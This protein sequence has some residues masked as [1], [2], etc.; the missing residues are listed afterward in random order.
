VFSSKTISAKDMQN[1]E[2]YFTDENCGVGIRT[3]KGNVNI[4]GNLI[5]DNETIVNIFES[6]QS[7]L[8]YLFIHTVSSTEGKVYLYNN[9]QL[10]LK[11]SGLSITS[12]SE[13]LD[14][15]QGYRNLF[16]FANG[17]DD[18]HYIELGATPDCGVIEAVDSDSRP[19]KGLGLANYAGR[20]WTFVDNR[21][22]YCVT[23]DVTDWATSQADIATSAGYIEFGKKIT[24]IVPYIFSLAVFFE[25]SS[26]IITGEYPFAA[27]EES[28]GGCAGYNAL[29]F[30]GTDLFFY[31][32]SKKGIYTFQQVVLG[33][34]TLGNNIAL[35]IQ[36]ELTNI[37]RS[38]INQIKMLS[39]NYNE[40]NEIWFLLPTTDNYSTILIYDYVK[41]EW[42]KR[43]SQKL[44]AIRIYD[45]NLYSATKNKVLKEYQ[46]TTFD[47]E[48]IQAFYKTSV[49]NSGSNTTLK[50]CWHAPVISLQAAENNFQVEYQKDMNTFKS[51]NKKKINADLKN[52]FEWNVSN[53]NEQY[54]YAP[55]AVK[56]LCRLPKPGNFKTLE[57]TFKSD[58]GHEN[59]SIQSFEFGEI[60]AVQT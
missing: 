8:H 26:V 47:G 22:H 21:L 51:Y 13:G 27:T 41:Q 38:R 2:L 42:I 50:G 53:W 34:R 12:V 45:N 5:P 7:G 40:R 57:I 11:L 31:D 23:S 54:W 24:A 16:I 46:G 28:P 37:D 58:G 29:T 56:S 10:T 25:D 9:S 4:T 60:Q 48:E 15:A 17:V 35:N 49:F 30:H 14:Y 1:V 20:V 18:L 44:T 33:N 6:V 32:D 19:I 39:V 52:Y 55:N 59:F 43:K 3:Q 36:N